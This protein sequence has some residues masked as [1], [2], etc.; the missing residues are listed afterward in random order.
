MR[1]GAILI[2]LLFSISP[3]VDC[4]RILSSKFIFVYCVFH[5]LKK[6]MIDYK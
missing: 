1:L 2:L 4:E 6:K 5:V 3:V